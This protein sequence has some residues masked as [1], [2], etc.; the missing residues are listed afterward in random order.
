MEDDVELAK[1][2]SVVDE[3]HDDVAEMTSLP[4]LQSMLERMESQAG[5]IVANE[6]AAVIE[7]SDAEL[8]DDIGRARLRKICEDYDLNGSA[9]LATTNDV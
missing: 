7:G 2:M 1:W 8:L 4:A 5:R 6:L 9:L 3:Q